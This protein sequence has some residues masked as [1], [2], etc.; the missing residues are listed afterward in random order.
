M[1]IKV[2][3]HIHTIHSKHAYSTLNEIVSEGIKRGLEGII[4]TE[5]F[6]P[7]Y[8]G[9]NT[10]DYYAGITNIRNISNYIKDLKIINGVEIDIVSK[11]GDLAFENEYFDFDK[12]DTIANK[13]F[14][15]VN[16]V[17]ASYHNF[18][19]ENNNDIDITE[20]LLRV[21]ENKNVHVLGHIDRIQKKYN[22]EEI[23][24]YA[25]KYNK[26]IEVNELSL[27]KDS[28]INKIV[29]ILKLCKKYN[30]NISIGS[31]A[32]ISSQVGDFSKSVELLKKIN[33]PENLI[34]NKNLD[35]LTRFLNFHK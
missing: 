16:F 22:I 35:S 10:F 11:Y 3:T 30:V 8:S 29:E 31:D 9:Q 12:K 17:I 7:M 6:G 20:T 2:D 1:I 32:H 34:I 5:H 27:K 33:F 24:K 21:I 26:A 14:S 4:I 25:K 19:M 13:L 18:D 23:V 15:K 28:S